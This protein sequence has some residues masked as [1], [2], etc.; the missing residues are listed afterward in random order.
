MAAKKK[1]KGKASKRGEP[2]SPRTREERL[3]K[4]RA[5]ERVYREKKKGKV[6]KP[7]APAL[8]YP[9]AFRAPRDW[10]QYHGFFAAE[11]RCFQG[12]IKRCERVKPDEEAVRLKAELR[13]E[14]L[15]AERRIVKP[16]GTDTVGKV[17]AEALSAEDLQFFALP[18]AEQDRRDRV[19]EAQVWR[20]VLARGR[21]LVEADDAAELEWV[22]EQGLADVVEARTGR[23]MR[24]AG[25]LPIMPWEEWLRHE[26]QRLVG[27]YGQGSRA[28]AR[29]AI[30]LRVAEAATGA[31]R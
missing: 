6:S 27:F 24:S 28:R 4:R 13:A 17:G 29:A 9:V 3:A 16:Q 5:R 14:R 7:A 1:A 2:E 21:E 18:V 25:D 12:K 19:A 20:R 15:P 26:T 8:P 23:G 11:D 30:L 10:K 22:L 31:E